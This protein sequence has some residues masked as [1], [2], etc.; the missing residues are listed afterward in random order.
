MYVIFLFPAW[1]EENCSTGFRTERHSTREVEWQFIF[2]F[3]QC[4]GSGSGGSVIKWPSGSGFVT[5]DPDPYYLLFYQEEI[6]ECKEDK[7][8]FEIESS[9]YPNKKELQSKKVPY[10]YLL[11]I[12]KNNS[13]AAKKF[14]KDPDSDVRIR[15]SEIRIRNEI[16]TD[17]HHCFNHIK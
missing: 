1:R 15:G 3:I 14:W 7:P 16:F 11:F 8:D 12:K 6:L 13:K 10:L 9:I 4:C 17:P 5:T 2:F